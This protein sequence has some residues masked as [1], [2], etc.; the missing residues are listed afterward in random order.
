MAT[1][2]P[3]AAPAPFVKLLRKSI[4]GRGLSLRDIGRQVGVSTAYMS[5]LVNKQRG[6]PADDTLIKLEH[7]LDIHPRGALFYAA[8][9]LD[10]AT[11]RVMERQPAQI[12]MR[13]LAKLTDDEM[14]QVQKVAQQYA[15]NRKRNAK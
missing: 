5:R 7:V 12:L 6:L 13:T 3:T 10:A 2:E 14:A 1:Q 15:N 4:A 11:S 9:R 8:G